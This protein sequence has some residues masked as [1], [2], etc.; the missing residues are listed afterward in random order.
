[1]EEIAHYRKITKE[2]FKKVCTPGNEW[3]W[4][5]FKEDTYIF[6]Y[7]DEPSKPY[8]ISGEKLKEL[9]YEL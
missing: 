5:V 9:S 6:Y 8:F 7:K 3:M 1:M 4:D 2:D